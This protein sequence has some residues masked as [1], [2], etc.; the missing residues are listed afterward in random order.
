MSFHIL[1][2][3]F[4]QTISALTCAT[5]IDGT[6]K[7]QGSVDINHADIKTIANRLKG[8]GEFKAKAI[9]EY[10]SKYGAF[11]RCDEL[12]CVK[13][14]GVKTLQKISRHVCLK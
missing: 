12:V 6:S 3:F 7:D 4:N 10:R 11:R 13:G 2:K 14:I 1:Y 8:I 5:A 9:V